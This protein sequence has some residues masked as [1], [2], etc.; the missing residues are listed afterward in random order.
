MVE[1]GVIF[2][3][4]ITKMWGVSSISYTKNLQIV[5][6]MFEQGACKNTCEFAKKMV[7]MSGDVDVGN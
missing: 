2:G 4:T 5:A 7:Q 1:S 3:I 6:I